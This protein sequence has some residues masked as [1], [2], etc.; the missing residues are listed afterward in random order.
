MSDDPSDNDDSSGSDSDLPTKEK[1][2]IKKPLSWRSTELNEVMSRLDRRIARRKSAKGH[3][4][5]LKT[6]GWA[7]LI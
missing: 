7:P 6:K 2:L 4:M 1:V 3:S 5:T